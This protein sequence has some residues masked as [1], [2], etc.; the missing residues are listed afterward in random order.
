MAHLHL[1]DA[2]IDNH[3]ARF[4]LRPPLRAATDRRGL[5]RAV[6]NGGIDVI[7]AQ[8]EPHDQDAKAAPFAASEP[9][10][11]GFDTFIPLMLDLVRRGQLELSRAVSAA[12]VAPAAVIGLPP[13][14]L[15]AGAIADLCIVDPERQWRAG[16]ATFASAGKN[17]PFSGRT[18]TGRAVLTAVGGRIVWEDSDA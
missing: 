14:A 10:A 8:H 6:A 16:A 13:P 2:D 5:V 1:C 3:D 12:T 11:S 17:S 7:S 9:G 15:G 18:L 4:H